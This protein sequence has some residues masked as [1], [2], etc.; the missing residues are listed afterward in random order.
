MSGLKVVESFGCRSSQQVSVRGAIVVE[1]QQQQKVVVL[2]SGIVEF[3]EGLL[4]VMNVP[5][6]ISV[7]DFGLGLLLKGGDLSFNFVGF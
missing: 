6:P 2:L 3:E 5:L 4:L 7:G 1:Q